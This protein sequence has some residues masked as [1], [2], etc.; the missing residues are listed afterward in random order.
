MFK[1]RNLIL[2]KLKLHNAAEEGRIKA[3]NFLYLKGFSLNLLTNNFNSLLHL[4]CLEKQENVIKWLLERN[5]NIKNRVNLFH[6]FTI[7]HSIFH[8]FSYFLSFL[9]FSNSIL[10]FQII[11]FII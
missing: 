1:E 6:Y 2:G 3:L 4:S 9:L 5:I 7:F 11:S 10:F 8:Y